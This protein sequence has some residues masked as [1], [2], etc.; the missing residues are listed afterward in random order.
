MPF[1]FIEF[2]RD[3]HI[4]T[5]GPGRGETHHVR[6]GWIGAKCPLCQTDHLGFNI[7]SGGFS[8]WRCGGLRTEDVIRWLAHC[9]KNKAWEIR[10]KYDDRTKH[11]RVPDTR[12]R[13]TR[14]DAVQRPLGL[15]PLSKH[16]LAYLRARGLTRAA[17]VAREWD[18][19]GTGHLGGPWAWR[20]VAPIYNENEKIVAYVGRAIADGVAP[21]Y[22]VTEASKCVESPDGFLYGI[23]KAKEDVVVI[24]EGPGDVWRMGPGFVATMS[25][26]WREEQVDKLRRRFKKRY[27]MFDPEGKAQKLA[28]KMAEWLSMFP[29]VTEVVDGLPSDPGSLDERTVRSIRKELL[30]G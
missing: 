25:M 30:G 14:P 16:H 27:I 13:K 29:G 10:K 12:R 6:D 1:N 8:C 11:T 26:N 28:Q 2:S 19:E 3:Y 9:D 20:V 17:S 7:S 15:A 18:L 5:F 21:K 4:P 22:R 24:V 23:H